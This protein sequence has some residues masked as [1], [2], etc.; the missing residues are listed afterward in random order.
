MIED[1]SVFTL[2]ASFGFCRIMKGTVLILE[3]KRSPWPGIW[4]A[5]LPPPNMNWLN[6]DVVFSSRHVYP[7]VGW[8]TLWRRFEGRSECVRWCWLSVRVRPSGFHVFGGVWCGKSKTF[9]GARTIGSWRWCSCLGLLSGVWW[10]A[11][12]LISLKT[13]WYSSVMISCLACS[14]ICSRSDLHLVV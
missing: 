4:W 10:F 9:H 3:S 13:F 11:F 8:G 7:S 6:L 14:R 2:V 5:S 12:C 1:V